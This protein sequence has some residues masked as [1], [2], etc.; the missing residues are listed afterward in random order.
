VTGDLNV[1]LGSGN[2]KLQ[3]DNVSVGGDFNIDKSTADGQGANIELNKVTVAATRELNIDTSGDT[4]S[5]QIRIEATSATTLNVTT[6]SGGDTMIFGDKDRGHGHAYS[7]GWGHGRSNKSHET[8][9]T[10]TTANVS[11]G[12]GNDTLDVSDTT[13]T[14]ANFD[15][16]GGTNTYTQGEDTTITTL[17]KSNFT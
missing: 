7:H 15:G 10:I 8:L 2:D 4:A 5:D 6:G 14:T 3:G 16:D 12:D 13:I 1:E 9:N 17:N 11:L